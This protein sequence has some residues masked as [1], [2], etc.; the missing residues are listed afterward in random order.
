MEVQRHVHT[1]ILVIKLLQGCAEHGTPGDIVRKSQEQ[2]TTAARGAKRRTGVNCKPGD[3][4]RNCQVNR[5]LQ[6]YEVRKDAQ[7]QTASLA[8]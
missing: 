8:T 2:G 6:Q 3:I 7:E 5:A 1:H 4:V